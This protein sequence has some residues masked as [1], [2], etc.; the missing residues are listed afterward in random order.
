MIRHNQ[1]HEAVLSVCGTSVSVCVCVCVCVCA[2][3]CVCVCVCE[4]VCECECV[5]LCVCAVVCVCVDVVGVVVVGCVFVKKRR[6]KGG[7][8]RVFYWRGEHKEPLLLLR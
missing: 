4:C 6:T 1:R 5:S 8:G 3:A 7:V 2:C